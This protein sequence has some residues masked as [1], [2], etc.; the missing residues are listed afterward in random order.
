MAGTVLFT[1]ASRG[2]CCEIQFGE[3]KDSDDPLLRRSD[4][5]QGLIYTL[6]SEWKKGDPVPTVRRHV[7]HP[8]SCQ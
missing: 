3:I 5:V 1:D 7:Q 6:P 2:L 4:T 8:R